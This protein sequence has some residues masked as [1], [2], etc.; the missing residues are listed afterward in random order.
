[1]VPIRIP[2]RRLSP[3]VLAAK[4]TTAGP[5]LQPKS[6]ASASRAK[7]VVPP[8]GIEALAIL[9]LPG[10]IIP[11]DNPQIPH[12]IRLNAGEGAKEVKR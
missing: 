5:P 9:K 12:P 4:P 3:K 2:F 8:L 1:M 6:P 10:H 11:T 7:S